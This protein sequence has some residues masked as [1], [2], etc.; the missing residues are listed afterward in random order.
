[1]ECIEG[2]IET[3]DPE[4]IDSLIDELVDVQATGNLYE[5]LQPIAD[6]YGIPSY[7]DMVDLHQYVNERF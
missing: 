6:K 3:F 2:Y 7:I 5:D 4:L 1:M